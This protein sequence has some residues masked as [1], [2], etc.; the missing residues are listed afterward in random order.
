LNK[1]KKINIMRKKEKEYNSADYY[2]NN[3]NP[4]GYAASQKQCLALPKV[5][6]L[7]TNHYEAIRFVIT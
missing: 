1:E 5:Y 6:L 7:I 4:E 2:K 3:K